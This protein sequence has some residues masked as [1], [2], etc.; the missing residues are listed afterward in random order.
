MKKQKAFTVIELLV[1]IAIIGL[2]SSIV[3]VSIKGAR[4]KAR[5]AS[6]LQFSAS[7]KNAIGDRI[8]GEWRFE[9][10]DGNS[11]ADT[12]GNDNNG[13][14]NE[15]GDHW[16]PNDISQLGTAGKFDGDDYVK[17]SSSSSLDTLNGSEGITLEVWVYS[18][19]LDSVKR[20]AYRYPN[21]SLSTFGKKARFI[22]YSSSP[23][24]RVILTNSDLEENSWV[25]IVATYNGTESE[26]FINGKEDTSENFGTSDPLDDSS[27][28]LF[29]GFTFDS[30]DGFL[31]K[32]KY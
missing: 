32:V 26:I 31:D 1:V 29:I 22:I 21:F 10:G 5:I 12:S 2:L 25:H 24:V 3:L 16:E 14:W 13:T 11:V 9:E 15:V 20:I 8:V 30:W 4:K 28:S 19:S 6:L 27:A 17:I 18:S 7:I 23:S